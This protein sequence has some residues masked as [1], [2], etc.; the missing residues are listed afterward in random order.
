MLGLSSVLKFV[1]NRKENTK[2]FN[3]LEIFYSPI[4]CFL[5]LY[6]ASSNRDTDK[7]H[8]VKFHGL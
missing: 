2:E 3:F 8:I 6:L 1:L 4:Q 7:G 5:F